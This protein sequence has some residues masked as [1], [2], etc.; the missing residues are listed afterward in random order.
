[1]TSKR[2]IVQSDRFQNVSSI[3]LSKLMADRFLTYYEGFFI[4]IPK[5]RNTIPLTYKMVICNG[6]P[7]SIIEFKITNENV[8][9]LNIC[10][11]QT[12][13]HNTPFTLSKNGIAALFYNTNQAL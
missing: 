13:D 11:M 6:Q 5:H 9:S 12:S 2:A 10:F 8:E 3:F 7:I 4:A 1:M